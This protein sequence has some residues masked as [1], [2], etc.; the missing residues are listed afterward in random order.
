MLL[1]RNGLASALATL[2]VFAFCAVLWLILA[3]AVVII[4]VCVIVALVDWRQRE[5]W[6]RRSEWPWDA[7]CA[8]GR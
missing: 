1:L 8:Y 2:C 3:L 6:D 4:A 7:R 5:R